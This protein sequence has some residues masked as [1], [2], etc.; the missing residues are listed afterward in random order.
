MS[1]KASLIL[2]VSFSLLFLI[3]GRF[4][5]EL[6]TRSVEN[7]VEYYEGT[8]AHNIAVSG[9]NIALN[10][11]FRNSGWMAGINN[12]AFDKGVMNVNVTIPDTMTKLITSTGT[13]MGVQRVVKVKF[14]RSTFAKYA[15]FT[16][17][18]SSSKVF[19][20]GDTI[21][22]GMHTNQTLNIEGDPVFFGKVTTSKGL[23]PS[24]SQI[25][26][27]GYHPKFLGGYATGVNVYFDNNYQFPTQR[28]AALSGGRYYDGT[29]LWLQFNSNGT[30]TYRTGM[31]KDT[32]KY[33]APVTTALSAFTSNG[34]VYVNRGDIFVSGTLSGQITI[35]ADQSS[36]TGGGNVYFINDLVY[37]VAPMIKMA[38]GDYEANQSCTDL[39]GVLA[40][41]NAFISS[42]VITTGQ[43]NNV[44]NKD[45]RVDAGVFCAKGGLKVE[46][47]S[48]VPGLAG[49]F[50]LN[51]SMVA[52]TEEDIAKTNNKTH[53]ISQGY[54]KHV[55]YDD[56]FHYTPPLYFPLSNDYEVLSWLE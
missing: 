48:E 9:A 20:T 8:I 52:G 55:V 3:M 46:N 4:W 36:G 39:M 14:G 43:L 24:D 19:I 11:I 37:S 25:K 38:N 12:R 18:V 21:W 33:S 45:L 54:T 44:V 51:G 41:N 40:S 10:N 15:W 13:F 35:V 32:S 28:S 23:K 27:L 47:W 16:G 1:G 22:G 17:S 42:S 34:I 53:M 2:I 56:R 31:G 49:V 30:V 26:K 5:D 6:A 29:D 50:Y 7:D